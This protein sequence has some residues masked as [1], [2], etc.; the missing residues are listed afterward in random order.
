MDLHEGTIGV[1]SAG[2]GKGTRFTLELP[3]SRTTVT[4]NDQGNMSRSMRNARNRSMAEDQSLMFTRSRPPS[5]HDAAVEGMPELPLSPLQSNGYNSESA[6]NS[7]KGLRHATEIDLQPTAAYL[8]PDAACANANAEEVRKPMVV[9]PPPASGY[10]GGGHGPM[11]SK[12]DNLPPSPSSNDIALCKGNLML[13]EL[14]RRDVLNPQ[15]GSVNYCALSGKHKN[16]NKRGVYLGSPVVSQRSQPSQHSQ[17]SQRSPEV[18]TTMAPDA[19]DEVRSPDANVPSS[20]ERPASPVAPVNA[21]TMA[22]Q[23]VSV[24]VL[25]K[26]D[27]LVVDDSPLNRKML[28]RILRAAGHTC[29]EAGNGREGVDMVQRR[30]DNRAT[31]YDVILMDFVMPVMNGP[32]AT[33]VHK[34]YTQHKTRL[35][36]PLTS[37][38]LTTHPY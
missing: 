28:M 19:A 33:K 15:T 6:S 12:G 11:F 36:H 18:N 35:T 16:D 13:R 31:P 23:G 10:G 2:E 32:T 8:R 7:M 14:S 1:Y 9:Q 4:G 34:P 21:S 26:W 22:E 20:E 29:E 3:M 17:Y 30:V 25:P 24:P 37:H 27:I 5:S 38:P